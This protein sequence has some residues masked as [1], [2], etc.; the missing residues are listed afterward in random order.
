MS[1]RSVN[2][3]LEDGQ[4]WFGEMNVPSTAE[5]GRT[6]AVTPLSE[7]SEKGEKGWDLYSCVYRYRSISR[8]PLGLRLQCTV[9]HAPSGGDSERPTP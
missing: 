8:Y 5:P 9:C 6:E 2:P 3:S 4:T 7:G 1:T